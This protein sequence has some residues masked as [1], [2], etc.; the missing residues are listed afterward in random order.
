MY[1]TF[2]WENRIFLSKYVK[3]VQ[4]I[5]RVHRKFKMTLRGLD[6]KIFR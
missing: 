1:K 3:H 4:G 6:L 5:S 2:D